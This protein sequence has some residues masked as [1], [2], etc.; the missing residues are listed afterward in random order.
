MGKK[1]QLFRELMK[2]T[3]M[4]HEVALRNRNQIGHFQG[5]GQ[6]I[7]V[8]GRHDNHYFQNELAKQVHVRPGS[9][10]QVLTRLEK[11]GLIT[12]HRD[13]QD[14]RQV[15]V[16]LTEQG[17]LKNQELDAER[18]EFMDALLD[19]LT[20]EDCQALIRIG[21]LMTAGLQEHYQK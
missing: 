16:T 18:Q 12:R 1:Q 21:K 4:I 8:L 19:K 14:R 5:G 10:S 6:I 11:N 13:E 17:R 2:T 7:A 20:I 15:I 9:L 3:R